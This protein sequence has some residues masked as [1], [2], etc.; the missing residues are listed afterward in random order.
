[1]NSAPVHPFAEFTP[2]RTHTKVTDETRVFSA[3]LKRDL[4]G[5]DLTC[6]GLG[7]VDNDKRGPAGKK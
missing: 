3:D 4:Y 1:M 7:R 6:G 2:P 5:M